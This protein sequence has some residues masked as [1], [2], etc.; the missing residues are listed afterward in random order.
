MGGLLSVDDWLPESVRSADSQT[1]ARGRLVLYLGAAI[2]PTGLAFF[3]LYL[4]KGMPGPASGALAV[5][6]ATA[7]AIVGFRRTG[8]RARPFAS[9]FPWRETNLQRTACS[10]AISPGTGCADREAVGSCPSSL[11]Y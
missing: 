8:P 4:S 11:P 9:R 1:V 10:R 2:A 6:V 7:A 5:S 3:L